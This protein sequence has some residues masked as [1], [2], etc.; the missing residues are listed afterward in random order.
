MNIDNKTRQR[1]QFLSRVVA[2][3]RDHLLVTDQRL[4]SLRFNFPGS[5]VR[6]VQSHISQRPCR[7]A[8]VPERHQ[9]AGGDRD[10][11]HR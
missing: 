4:F 3:E 9:A 5:L 11:C 2:K 1:L 7:E 10:H 6:E 8:H